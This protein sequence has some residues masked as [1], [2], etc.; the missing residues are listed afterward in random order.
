M[1][2]PTSPPSFVVKL[3]NG[4]VRLFSSS[5]SYVRSLAS[6]ATS[7]VVQGDQVHVTLPNGSVRIY[8]VRGQYVRTL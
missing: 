6:G 3:V 7:A 4:Q 8:T 1:P 2:N 5:G